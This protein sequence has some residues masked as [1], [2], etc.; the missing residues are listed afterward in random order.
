MGE[1][2]YI[3][4]ISIAANPHWEATGEGTSYVYAFWLADY[5][6]SDQDDGVQVLKAPGTHPDWF[7]HAR[8]AD[9]VLSGVC[10]PGVMV[11]DNYAAVFDELGGRFWAKPMLAS[12]LLGTADTIYATP[13][14]T[15]YWWCG[16]W[17]LTRRGK[18]IVRELTMLY[19]RGVHLVTFLDMRPMKEA[20]PGAAVGQATA[21]AVPG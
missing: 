10:P 16:Y 11:S 6:Q 18:R 14:R 8:T 15:E 9:Q 7:L 13:E 17:H 3:D 1:S 2:G 12:V 5:E 20:T 4:W 19:Q 21:T